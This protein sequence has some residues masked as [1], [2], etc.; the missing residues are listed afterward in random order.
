[1]TPIGLKTAIQNR[2]AYISTNLER[3]LKP[4]IRP[5]MNPYKQVEMWKKWMPIIPHEYW[6]DEFYQKPSPEVL[7]LVK[8]REEEQKGIPG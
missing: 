7:A 8:Y 1:M 3:L 2:Y 5:G 4:I 6:E